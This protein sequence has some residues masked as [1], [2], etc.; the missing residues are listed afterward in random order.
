[1][2][3]GFL[4]GLIGWA[5]YL[6]NA[7]AFFLL[8]AFVAYINRFQIGPEEKALGVLFGEQFVAYCSRVRRWL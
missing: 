1:M 2:Y 6:S 5:I 4:L 7:L 8:P 3:L